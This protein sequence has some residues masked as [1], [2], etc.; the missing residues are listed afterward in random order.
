MVRPVRPPEIPRQLEPVR[1]D[2]LLDGDEWSGCEIGGEFVGDRAHD[3]EIAE[4][5]LSQV[6]LTG[7]DLSR[8]R[9]RDVMFDGCD[10]SGAVLEEA[11]L[12]RC[13]FVDCRLSGMVLTAAHLRNVTFRACRMD[14]LG[15]RMIN[16]QMVRIDGCDLSGSDLYA[17][18]FSDSQI[19]DSDLT[20]ADLSGATL[21]GSELHGSRL[22]GVVGA[23][24]LRGAV[25]DPVQ[26]PAVGLALLAAHGISITDEPSK[27]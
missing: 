16:A 10:L 22:E 5:R 8:L 26:A 4:A 14:L 1:I 24:A 23:L 20:G 11:H 13:S 15:M 9:L 12:T 7:S 3:V 6:R 19:I 25:V 2:G 17:A 18:Q 21:S 27:A